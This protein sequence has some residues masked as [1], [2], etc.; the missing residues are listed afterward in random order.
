M[1]AGPMPPVC[2]LAGGLGS[3]LGELVRDVPKPLLELAGEPFLVHQ[4]RLLAGY[5][6]REAVICVGYRGEQIESRIGRERFGIRLAYSHDSP[7]LDGTLGAIRRAL[8]LLG[9][10]FLVLYGDTYLRLDYRAAN[11][12]WHE[13][14]Q[15]GLM[16]VLRNEGRWDVSN[17]HYENH[18]VLDYDKHSPTKAMRWIDYGLGGLY[19]EAIHDFPGSESDLAALYS[20]L[21]RCGEL[22]GYPVTNRFYE[23]GTPSALAETEL[24]LRTGAP[25]IA[26]TPRAVS[27]RRP[28]A[29]RR[30]GASR[31]SC[32]G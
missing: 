19:A 2:I 10:R 22:C 23:I 13:S 12:I 21:A 17:A 16:A 15:L 7:E 24:F 18:R 25:S 8:G 32:G 1:S 27:I 5:D 14:G 20:D 6:V 4:L 30:R 29:D 3:R 28:A 9:D 11:R 31:G 26:G